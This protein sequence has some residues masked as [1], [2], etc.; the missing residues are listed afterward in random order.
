MA[1]TAKHVASVVNVATTTSARIH[2]RRVVSGFLSLAFRSSTAMASTSWSGE[3]HDLK[4]HTDVGQVLGVWMKNAKDCT[5]TATAAPQSVE[6]HTRRA[7]DLHFVRNAGFYT[8]PQPAATGFAQ[9]GGGL[10]CSTS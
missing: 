8:I 4:M 3:P 2:C 9:R 5:C 6:S 10:C 7:R 1:Y